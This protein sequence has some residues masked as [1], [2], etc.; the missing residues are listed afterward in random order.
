M[1]LKRTLPECSGIYYYKTQSLVQT[2]SFWVSTYISGNAAG[3]KFRSLMPI[4]PTSE[5]SVFSTV[6]LHPIKSILSFCEEH[7]FRMSFS[8]FHV[9]FSITSTSSKS[10]LN[11]EYTVPDVPGGWGH[12]G[13]PEI[14]CFFMQFLHHFE[15]QAEVRFRMSTWTLDMYHVNIRL[16][17]CNIYRY[18]AFNSRAD[19]R[20]PWGI[21]N[22]DSCLLIFLHNVIT[23]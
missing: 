23:S 9:D 4:S 3:S 7:V 21:G 13:H 14:P 10:G 2:T 20:F 15:N 17:P 16:L 19:V 12:K 22:F 11:K 8:Q 18:F 5:D 1:C 6:L